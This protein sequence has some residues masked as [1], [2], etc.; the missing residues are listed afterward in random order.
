MFRLLSP[1]KSKDLS[2]VEQADMALVRWNEKHPDSP[3][4]YSEPNKWI[5][6]NGET[7]Y[8]T[9]EQHAQ[10]AK[11]SGQMAQ[12][13]VAGIE[14]NPLEPS[15]QEI[16]KIKAAIAKGRKMARAALLPSWTFD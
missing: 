16:R 3:E 11:L 15:Y 14:F 10:Y 6:I 2:T 4:I 7:Q 5:K 8:L 13:L 12:E 9:D 1:V